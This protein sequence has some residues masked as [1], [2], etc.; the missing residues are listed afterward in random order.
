M[1]R[2]GTRGCVIGFE[3]GRAATSIATS[4]HVNVGII[5][6]IV[7]DQGC[8]FKGGIHNW[9]AQAHTAARFASRRLKLH[10]NVVIN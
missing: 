8:G 9:D 7:A 4:I 2:E 5:F 3:S 6:K 1:S 10:Q